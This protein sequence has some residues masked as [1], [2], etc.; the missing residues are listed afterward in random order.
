MLVLMLG[1]FQ[2]LHSLDVPVLKGR[3][4]DYANILAITEENTLEVL[5]EEI[6]NKTSSQ[7]V[8]LTVRSLEG[9]ILEN[10][11]M[12]VAEEWKIG[13]KKF[14][15]GVILLIAMEEKKIR[16]EVGY[17]LESILTDVKCGYII[18]KIIVEHFRKGNFYQGIL[19]GLQTITGI[20]SREFDI[21]DEE[22]ARFKRDR[23]KKKKVFIPIGFFIFFIILILLS[24]KGGHR[25]GGNV[26]WGSGFGSGGFSGGG[27]S[28][29]GGSFGGGGASGGW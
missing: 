24:L 11:S 6:E 17:G 9:E 21:S 12:K 13:Q 1:I 27:F 7:V 3:I 8:L 15:N 19:Q 2:L 14:D 4:N 25:R 16:I 10:Y 26:F 5:L 29:G 18:R 20:I 22:L 23:G 28:G